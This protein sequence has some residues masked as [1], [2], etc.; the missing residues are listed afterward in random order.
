MPNAFKLF[1]K[2]VD[3]INRTV[4]R[5]AMYLIF[6]MMGILIFSAISR[7]VF[8][9]PYIWAAYYLLGGGY[10]MQNDAHVRMDLLYERWPVKKTCFCRLYHRLL[11]DFLSWC[12]ILWGMVEYRICSS[13]WAEKLFFLGTS[14]G[15]H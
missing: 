1:V 4:G 9:V 7:S 10:T 5:F 14:D 8:N 2:Y 12:L 15:S 13:I 11:P 6:L 3:M